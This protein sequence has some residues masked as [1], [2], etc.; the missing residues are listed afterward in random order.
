MSSISTIF[1]HCPSCGRRFEIRLVG[2]KEVDEE[3]MIEDEKRPSMLGP[4]V[5]VATPVPALL[6]KD[7][8]L[9][10]NVKDFQYTYQCKHCGHQWSEIRKKDETI[11]TPDG[12]TG[13]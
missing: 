4:F 3:D 13:D 2:K 9:M 8:P 7:V 12:Y 6:Q 5:S 11:D 10:V 1:R